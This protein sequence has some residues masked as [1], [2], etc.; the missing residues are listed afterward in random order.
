[1][2]VRSGED[3]L[4][5]GHS[6]EDRLVLVHSS[7]DR[8]DAGRSGEDRL[9]DRRGRRIFVLILQE[10]LF[11]WQ[12]DE[13]RENHGDP[14]ELV[15]SGGP[16]E[17]PGELVRHGDPNG[18]PGELVRRGG[19]NG[20]PGELVRRG[21]LSVDRGEGAQYELEDV[22]VHEPEDGL[23]CEVVRCEL[24][25][26]CEV[27]RYELEEEPLQEQEDGHQHEAEHRAGL[28]PAVQKPM[29]FLPKGQKG[30]GGLF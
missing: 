14:G 30:Q 20:D 11:Q 24:V 28:V 10:L 19:P 25:P 5:A 1:M 22:L 16:N 8:L 2:P 18:D 26:R 12:L 4:D 21:D 15:R 23:R 9:E 13:V 17:G 6:G 29:R 3:R 27:V 7:E